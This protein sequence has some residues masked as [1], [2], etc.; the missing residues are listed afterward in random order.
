MRTEISTIGG[1]IRSDSD[2]NM[3]VILVR[4][5]AKRAERSVDAIQA[6]HVALALV[7]RRR[8]RLAL[9]E[10]AALQQRPQPPRPLHAAVVFLASV[11]AALK[12]SSE[13]QKRTEPHKQTKKK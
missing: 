13:N 11:C 2:L 4:V 3:A 1:R 9:A 12:S 5:E 7:R 8:V 10:E 6:E